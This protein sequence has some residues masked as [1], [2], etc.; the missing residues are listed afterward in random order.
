M[1]FKSSPSW[2]IYSI[3]LWSGYAITLDRPIMSRFSTP[4]NKVLWGSAQSSPPPCGLRAYAPLSHLPSLRSLMDLLEKYKLWTNIVYFFFILLALPLSRV[5]FSNIL[6]P[7]S[8]HR[9]KSSK[10]LIWTYVWNPY[11]KLLI[12][13][14]NICTILFFYPA[15]R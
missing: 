1:A 10:I 12:V 9:I 8:S 15:V 5:M 13:P 6:Y 3:T 2:T 7:F 14:D 11:H 4:S